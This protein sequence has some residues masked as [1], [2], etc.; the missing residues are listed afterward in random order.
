MRE[1]LL[2]TILLS[3]LPALDQTAPSVSLRAQP[4]QVAVGDSVVLSVNYRWLADAPPAQMPDPSAALAQEIVSAIKGPDRSTA[5]GIVE[6]SWTATVV[7]RSS[8]TWQAPV[9]ELA[10]DDTPVRS[11]EVLITVGTASTEAAL[12]PPSALW[13]RSAIPPE[14]QAA[15]WPW[16]VAI[17]VLL[18]IAALAA[19]LLLRRRRPGPTPFQR[20]STELA[21]VLEASE[22]AEAGAR[23]AGCLRRYCG[24]RWAFDGAGATGRELIDHLHDELPSTD[25]A[26][27]RRIMNHLDDL[28]FSPEGL[29]LAQVRSLLDEGRSWVSRQEHRLAAE[30][31]ATE[32]AA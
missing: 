15:I 31:Q 11:S 10:V 17:I 1:L 25:L 6:H 7:M 14:Q 26:Q 20:F 16:V 13:T 4:T 30:A 12:P 22:A 21:Q 2:L 19:V 9:F 27:L 18:L 24:R 28:R 5:D 3:A 29:A 32:D 23:L 8:G